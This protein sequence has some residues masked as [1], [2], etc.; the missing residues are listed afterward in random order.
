[1]VKV[2]K[3]ENI[4]FLALANLV[5]VEAVTVIVISSSSSS[6]SSCSSNSSSGVRTEV[7]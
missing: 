3:E 7:F 1:M 4:E 6:S 2:I 5:K